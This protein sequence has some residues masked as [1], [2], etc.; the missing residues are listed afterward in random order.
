MKTVKSKLNLDET[1]TVERRL[2][3]HETRTVE[4]KLTGM[5][6]NETSDF[7]FFERVRS[8]FDRLFDLENRT[9]TTRIVSRRFTNQ[10][11]GSLEEIKIELYK[12]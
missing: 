10:A 8:M 9:L 2:N 7:N 3:R 1:R 6:R 5:K 12:S 11:T 4:S